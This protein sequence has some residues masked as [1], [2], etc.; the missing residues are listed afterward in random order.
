MKKIEQA[1]ATHLIDYKN[2]GIESDDYSVFL[3]K[4]ADK[5]FD[6][7]KNRIDLLRAG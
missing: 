4:R 2:S 7:L 1:L 3:Q 6:E 5:I